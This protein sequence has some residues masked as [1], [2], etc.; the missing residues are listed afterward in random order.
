MQIVRDEEK[1]TVT[2]TWDAG[3]YGHV[4]NIKVIGKEVNL[5]SE[6]PIKEVSRVISLANINSLFIGSNY[7]DTNYYYTVVITKLDGTQITKDFE[8]I[9]NPELLKKE[10][11]VIFKDE[12][13]NILKTETVEEGESATAPNAPTKE[14]YNFVGWDKDFT[15]VTE[16]LEVKPLY[17]V[18]VIEDDDKESGCKKDLIYLVSS[19]IALTSLAFVTLRKKNN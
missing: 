3:T 4:D 2:L 12:N 13:G 18:I 15:N 5:Y 16:N 10:Y 8:F 9:N 7:S 1:E 6:R 11:E 14:G 19:C 17:E